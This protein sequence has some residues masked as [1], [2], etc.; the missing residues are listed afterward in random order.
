MF[1]A[2]RNEPLGNALS[3]AA[4]SSD[5]HVGSLRAAEG[6]GALTRYDVDIALGSR[7]G[8][9]LAHVSPLLHHPHDMLHI[10]YGVWSDWVHRPVATVLAEFDALAN[11]VIQ[12]RALVFVAVQKVKAG[13]QSATTER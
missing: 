7:D 10:S 12:D 11:R 4:K 6:R 2:L 9:K 13:N 3:S 8:D 5:Y 1:G